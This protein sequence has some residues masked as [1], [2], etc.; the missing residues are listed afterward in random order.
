MLTGLKSNFFQNSIKDRMHFT[1][2]VII[3]RRRYNKV[4]YAFFYLIDGWETFIFVRVIAITEYK[5]NV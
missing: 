4:F 3:K 2:Y 1:T 5:T